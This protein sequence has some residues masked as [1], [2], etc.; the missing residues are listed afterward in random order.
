MSLK[1]RVGRRIYHT[2][3][4]R[5]RLREPEPVIVTH[6][7]ISVCLLKVVKGRHDVKRCQSPHSGRMVERE[8]VPNTTAPIVADDAEFL[9]PE[10]IHEVDDVIRDG[11]L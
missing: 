1:P 9:K 3:W 4:K 10:A 11:T 6:S 7:E 5:P 8:P 2:L